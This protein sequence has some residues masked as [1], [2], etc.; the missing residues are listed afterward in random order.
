MINIACDR[1]DLYRMDDLESGSRY[2]GEGAVYVCA[3][4]GRIDNLKWA[5]SDLTV[6]AWV[7]AGAPLLFDDSGEAGFHW[8]EQWKQLRG[9]IEK[10]GLK[11]CRIVFLQQNERA[12]EY[13]RAAFS[14]QSAIEVEIVLFHYWLHR[15][16]L[17]AKRETVTAKR[18]HRYAC[19][20]R[21][22][23]DHR[24]K[25]LSWIEANGFMDCGLVSHEGKQLGDDARAQTVP[26]KEHA[27][28]GFCLI[29]ETEMTSGHVVRFTEKALKALAT[30]NLFL[31]AGNPGTLS[32]LRSMGFRT[33]GSVVDESYD[34]ITDP[35]KRLDAVLIEAGKLIAM[36]NEAFDHVLR[37]TQDARAHNTRHFFDGLPAYMERQHMALLN[38]VTDKAIAQAA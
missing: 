4:I 8:P 3:S 38:A 37:Q 16:R 18:T 11:R 35:D 30:G 9:E 34:Q 5:L 25:V 20:N 17:D 15:L 2:R 19:F 32:L 22:M 29:N 24:V 27:Q 12:K 36:D 13:A 7:E 26:W 23:R 31:I 14:G 28:V 21:K 10:L 33:F 1:P 6:R